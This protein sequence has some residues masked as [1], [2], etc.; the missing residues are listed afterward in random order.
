MLNMFI[1]KPKLSGMRVSFI[2]LG[3]LFFISTKTMGQQKEGIKFGKVTAADFKITS[4]VVDTNANA[5]IISDIGSTEFVGNNSGDFTLVFKQYKRIWLRNRNAFDAATIHVPIYLGIT[6][7][8]QEKFEDFE[9]ATYNLENGQV[10]ET[11]LDKAAVFTEKINKEQIERKFTFP[12]LKEGC[13]IE[14]RYTV[15]SPFYRHLRSWYFQGQYPC[16]WSEYKVMIPHMFNYFVT[17]RG[18][19]PYTIDSVNKIYKNYSIVIPAADAF[20]SSDHVIVS[21]NAKFAMWAI[22]DVP[23]FKTESFTSSA[24]NYIN[25]IQFLLQSIQYSDDYTKM[26]IK[27]WIKTADELM[28]DPD[29]GL[30]LKDNNTWLNDL[31]PAISK[32]PDPLVKAKKIFEYVR[33]NFTCNDHDAYYLSQPLKKTYQTKAGNIIDINLLL[34]AIFINQGFDA[35]PVLLSTRSNGFVNESTAVL[36]QYNYALSRIKINDDYYLLDASYNRLGF[37]RLPEDCY[38]NSG[39]VVDK[40]PVLVSLS[41]DSLREEKQ[42]SLFIINGE[43]GGLE[44]SFS[45]TMGHYESYAVREKM[46]KLKKDDLLKEIR[47]GMAAEAKIQNLEIDSLKLY[48]EPLNIKYDV[49]FD[50]NGE[51]VIYFNPLLNE[52]MKQNPFTS[53]DRVYPVEMPYTTHEVFVLDMEIPKGYVVDELPKSVRYKLNETEGMFEYIFSKSPEKVQMRCKIDINKANFDK[54]D[55]GPLREF[56]SFII[57][58][59]SEQIV[60]KKIKQ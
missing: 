2:A 13:I 35:H 28:N 55:Y 56:Y 50:F 19:I 46:I 54:E 15:K 42:T 30:Q 29:F 16:L 44:G 26:Y 8:S 60:F 39:R 23:A 40:L 5:V 47:K 33:D 45:T 36:N 37:G 12:N 25:G 3:V 59:Q 22:K 4:P 21:G 18:L 9:A 32:E 49:T 24:L 57:K 52:A 14:Y 1:S 53:A 48:D 51:D 20:S 6:Y 27:D 34:T 10:T 11:R 7:D 31:S 41:P 43:K 17:R 38:N 58:K